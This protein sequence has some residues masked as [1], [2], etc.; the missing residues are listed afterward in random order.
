MEKWLNIRKS[1][2]KTHGSL[3]I[4]SQYRVEHVYE[5]ES[6]SMVTE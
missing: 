6:A 2:G 3:L 1:I 5:H 4:V